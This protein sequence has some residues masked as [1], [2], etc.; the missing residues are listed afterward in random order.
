MGE[1]QIFTTA[2]YSNNCAPRPCNNKTR[3]RRPVNPGEESLVPQK[4]VTRPNRRSNG[5]QWRLNGVAGQASH[6]SRGHDHSTCTGSVRFHSITRTGP[7]WPRTASNAQCTGAQ[8]TR[9][10]TQLNAALQPKRN[11]ADLTGG[12]TTSS[13]TLAAL[14]ASAGSLPKRDTA[15]YSDPK[16]S[17]PLGTPQFNNRGRA[18]TL[19]TESFAHPTFVALGSRRRQCHAMASAHARRMQLLDSLSALGAEASLIS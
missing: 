15:Q 16:R 17:T 7:Q 14:V 11:K 18:S 13:H 8:C 3:I 12:F 9:R 5:P 4:R 1:N 19:T 2:Q 10:S 6:C